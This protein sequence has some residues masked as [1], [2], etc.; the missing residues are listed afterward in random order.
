[1]T[2][3]HLSQ[4]LL[5][6]S[7]SQA[8]DQELTLLLQITRTRRTRRTPPIFFKQEWYQSLTLKTKSCSSPHVVQQSEM[9]QLLPYIFINLYILPEYKAGKESSDKILIGNL[10]HPLL[11]GGKNEVKLMTII[12]RIMG[13]TFL[14]SSVQLQLS[15]A[16][17]TLICNIPTN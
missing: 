11:Q 15:W 9:C 12:I 3:P 14:A 13:F 16:E 17:L 4:R 7:Q 10:S 6:S 2:L 1:M 8:Q 5:S